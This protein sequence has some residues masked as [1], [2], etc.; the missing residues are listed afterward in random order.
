MT[1]SPQLSLVARARAWLLPHVESS[2]ATVIAIQRA[3][4]VTPVSGAPRGFA[5]HLF[6]FAAELGNEITFILFLPFI[7]W[8][9]DTAVARQTVFLWCTSYYLCHYIKD[10]LQLPRPPPFAAC[11]AHAA[12][13]SRAARACMA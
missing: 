7:F 9:F 4:G 11:A 1:K 2:T 5:Y 13:P 6:S 12:A 3:F 8:E 10:S